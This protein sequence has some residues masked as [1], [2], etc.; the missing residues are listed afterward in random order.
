MQ[1][2]KQSLSFRFDLGFQAA[3]TFEMKFSVQ[4]NDPPVVEID[5]AARAAYIRFK[6][7]KVAKTISPE[8]SGAIV[9]IDLDK[10][11]NVIGVELIGVREF[12]LAVLLKKLPFLKAEVPVDRARYVP[13]RTAREPQMV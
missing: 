8:T 3:L 6:R 13:T 1:T 10:N 2:C 11:E 7:T 4:S 9:A 12:S 5:S